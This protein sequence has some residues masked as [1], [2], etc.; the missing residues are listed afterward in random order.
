[1]YYRVTGD[2]DMLYRTDI[3]L[4]WYLKN[5]LLKNKEIGMW[6]IPEVR[7]DGQKPRLTA[8]GSYQAGGGQVFY[9]AYL[10]LKK[11]E[12]KKACITL[13]DG[14]VD[15]WLKG[16]MKDGVLWHV[17]ANDDGAAISALCAYKLTCNKK[18]LDGIIGQ[19]ARYA[20]EGHNDKNRAGLP[21][22]INTML[23]LRKLSRDKSRDKL[24]ELLLAK[25]L[26]RQSSGGGFRGE[27]EPVKWYVKGANPDDFVVTRVTA[28]AA[29]A[30]FKAAGLKGF[31]YTVEI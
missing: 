24:I 20:A 21:C 17:G 27:D 26:K 22:A 13:A 30:L 1:M 5:A 15:Y 28:Y 9:N 8:A 19:M 14:Y 6:T 31:G 18:Y 23:E 29:L 12:Y 10:L 3:Y 11:P 4:K 2:K 7:F 16:G 25:L